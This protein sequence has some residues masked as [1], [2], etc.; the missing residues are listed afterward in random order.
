MFVLMKC[1]F[2]IETYSQGLQ[3]S[4]IQSSY[5]GGNGND[6]FFDAAYAAPNIVV[7]A[8]ATSSSNLPFSFEIANQTLGFNDGLIMALRTSGTFLHAH[9]YTID[10]TILYCTRV[11]GSSS[12]Q[13]RAI[14]IANDGSVIFGGMTA[15]TNFRIAGTFHKKIHPNDR[16]SIFGKF[17]R[18]KPRCLLWNIQHNDMLVQSE[19]FYLPFRYFAIL[20]VLGR[21]WH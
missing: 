21:Q 9:N 10:N 16:N 15:S 3:V 11:A 18:R 20:I 2:S 12:D 1:N 19:K 4:L 7:M 8:G 5:F 6:E 17:S 14:E 13:I